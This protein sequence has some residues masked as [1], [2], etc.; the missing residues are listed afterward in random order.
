MGVVNTK[1]NEITKLDLLTG[2]KISPLYGG[3]RII[4]KKATL[5]VAAADSNTST[6]RFFRAL[7]TWGV[8]GLYIANDAISSGLSFDFGLYDTAEN[9]GAVVDV[10]YF[11][12]AVSVVSARGAWTEISLEATSAGGDVANVEKAIWEVRALSADP[13][14]WYDVVGTA[15][16]VGSAAGTISLKGHF[17]VPN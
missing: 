12:S 8:D 7:S 3:Y 15:N 14:R 2:K 16:V 17:A 11:A 6:Y 13:M 5:E 4:G 1:S 9:G 10:D